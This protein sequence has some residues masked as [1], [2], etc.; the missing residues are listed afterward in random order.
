MCSLFECLV[1]RPYRGNGKRGETDLETARNRGMETKGHRFAT[2]VSLRTRKDE[3]KLTERWL[4]GSR[5]N[6]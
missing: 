4:S 1:S 2:F 5:G 6:V 3:V